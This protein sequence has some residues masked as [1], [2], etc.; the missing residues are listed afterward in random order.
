M[1]SPENTIQKFWDDR[2]RQF[3]H[4]GWSDPF[5][6]NFDQTARL[7]SLSSILAG[8]SLQTHLA[9]DFGCGTGDFANMLAGH[10]DRVIGFDISPE[11]ARLAEKRSRRRNVQF[12][13]GPGIEALQLPDHSL[14]LVISVTVL[15]HILEP[16]VL[17][18]T[19]RAIAGKLKPGG[20]FVCLESTPLQES[21]PSAYVFFRTKDQ[22]ESSFK[23][24]GLPVECRYG[25]YHPTDAPSAS[26]TRYYSGGIGRRLRRKARYILVRQVYSAFGKFC[27][28]AASDCH[29]EGRPDDL[30]SIYVCRKPTA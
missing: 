3:G 14:D 6:Y 8:T 20:V 22:W 27:V 24:A 9:L 2:A 5:I 30:M 7:Q 23:A 16:A 10:F 29:W 13:A 17:L 1:T 21:Q 12:V 26:F 28:R 25:F 19:L 11:V 15:Q 18:K 4:T